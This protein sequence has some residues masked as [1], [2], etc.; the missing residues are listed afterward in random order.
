MA[1]PKTVKCIV[2][3]GH[4]LRVGVQSGD[5]SLVRT[6][7]PGEEVSLSKEDAA[8]LMS[9][10]FLEDSGAVVVPTADGPSFDVQDGPTVTGA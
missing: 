7:G 4:T 2:A 9:C 10:G 6:A 1:T 5:D 8:W 3:K